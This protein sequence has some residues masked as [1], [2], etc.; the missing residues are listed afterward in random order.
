VLPGVCGP[1]R[2]E[3]G[4]VALVGD[5]PVGKARGGGGGGA[6][7][8]KLFRGDKS[9]AGKTGMAWQGRLKGAAGCTQG[10]GVWVSRGH[11]VYLRSQ[12]GY[13]RAR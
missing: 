9:V 6:C 1:A 2:P 8:L 13:C 12:A 11:R 5:G 3:M 4:W 7:G 10:G